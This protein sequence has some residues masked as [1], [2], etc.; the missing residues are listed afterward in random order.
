[1]EQ[2][3]Y[4]Y[5]SRKR[6]NKTSWYLASPAT[7][8]CLAVRLCAV[9]TVLVLGW[10]LF[11]PLNFMLPPS[12]SFPPTPACLPTS[13]CSSVSE[14]DLLRPGLFQ[15]LTL[16]GLDW[17]GCSLFLFFL[18]KGHC[19]TVKLLSGGSTRGILRVGSVESFVF[20][21][22]K[23]RK[24]KH[25]RIHICLGSAGLGLLHWLEKACP[26][27]RVLPRAQRGWGAHPWEYW[28]LSGKGTFLAPKL[29]QVLGVFSWEC[30]PRT[31]GK[32]HSWAAWYF[33]SWSSS[34]AAKCCT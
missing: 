11:W 29:L 13:C 16:P 31:K 4:V 30:N 7:F 5:D 33:C 3:S 22:N 18:C 27:S 6:V 23:K 32:F 17:V 9:H 15:R 28:C 34:P 20:S 19:A 1:M 24:R 26:S 25:L 14:F 2:T 10:H 12:P 21:L 8:I